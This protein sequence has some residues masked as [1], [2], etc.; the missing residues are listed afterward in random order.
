[1]ISH[2][3]TRPFHY[4]K[5][6]KSIALEPEAAGARAG[7]TAGAARAENAEVKANRRAK[8]AGRNFF[9]THPLKCVIITTQSQKK[10][11][12]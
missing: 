3:F 8:P 2:F 12:A 1:M 11:N 6:S 9:I 4:I 7:G 10:E 5:S